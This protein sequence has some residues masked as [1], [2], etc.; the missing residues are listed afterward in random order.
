MMKASAESEPSVAVRVVHCWEPWSPKPSFKTLSL[1][2]AKMA[3]P[4][5]PQ[6]ANMALP[7]KAVLVEVLIMQ[8][9]RGE[10][11][12]ETALCNEQGVAT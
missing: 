3:P 8:P 10:T 2:K 11:S 6:E 9:I 7:D 4:N 1:H 12:R 5:F